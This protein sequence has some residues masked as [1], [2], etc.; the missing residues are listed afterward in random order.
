M[1]WGRP[2]ML[3]MLSLPRFQKA[4]QAQKHVFTAFSEGFAKQRWRRRDAYDG[5]TANSRAQ[6]LFVGL[7]PEVPWKTL[8]F[9]EHCTHGVL[10]GGANS[11]LVVRCL[12]R[13]AF[14]SAVRRR[15]ASSETIQPAGAWRFM[16]TSN[17]NYKS[18]YNLLRGLRRFISTVIVRVISAHEPPSAHWMPQGQVC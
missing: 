5:C 2:L 3:M 12:T 13:G 8:P 10:G 6:A 17:P 11:G 14:L 7:L 1:A 18:T 16:G 15:L 9:F 4:S